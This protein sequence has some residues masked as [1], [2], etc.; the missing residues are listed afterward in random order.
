MNKLTLL[1]IALAMT[2]LPLSAQ[3]MTAQLAIENPGGIQP[4]ASATAL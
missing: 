1:T 2:N 3:T 4:K